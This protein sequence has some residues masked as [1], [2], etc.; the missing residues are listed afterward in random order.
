MCA[1]V[2][3]ARL[4]VLFLLMLLSQA[5]VA[6]AVTAWLEEGTLGIL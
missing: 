2:Q 1:W 3:E 6:D 5:F 4:V